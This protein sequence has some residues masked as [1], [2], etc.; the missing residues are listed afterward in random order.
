MLMNLKQTLEFIEQCN[1]SME[2]D[3]FA[4]ASN[5]AI[6]VA[7]ARNP[8]TSMLTLIK[9][10]HDSE[11]TVR[12]AASENPKLSKAIFKRIKD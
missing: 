10:S 2:L 8:N 7:V 12:D 4:I 1:S 3:D 9:L 6:K 11:T 5:P